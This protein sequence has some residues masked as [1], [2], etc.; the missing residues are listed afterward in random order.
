M[1]N[2][3]GGQLFSLYVC[4]NVSIA[5]TIHHIRKSFNCDSYAYITEEEKSKF[6]ARHGH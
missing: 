1:N 2:R 6:F 5:K 4:I 3:Y